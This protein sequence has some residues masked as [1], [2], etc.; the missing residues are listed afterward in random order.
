MVIR[1]DGQIPF[2]CQYMPIG[3]MGCPVQKNLARVQRVKMLKQ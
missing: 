2:E 3:T 1:L